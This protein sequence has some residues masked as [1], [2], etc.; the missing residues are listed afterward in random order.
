MIRHCYPIDAVRVLFIPPTGLINKPHQIHA[1]DVVMLP[2]H[3]I[4]QLMRTVRLIAAA[5]NPELLVIS[6][7]QKAKIRRIVQSF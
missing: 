1:F 6:I 4:Q 3:H 2:C 7:K 5:F